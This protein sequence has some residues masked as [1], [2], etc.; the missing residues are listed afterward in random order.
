MPLVQPAAVGDFDGLDD[1]DDDGLAL[2]ES[3]GDWDGLPVGAWAAAAG[4]A[5][6]D[7]L[8]L[9]DG[10]PVGDRDGELDGLPVGL[11]LGL[12]VGASTLHVPYGPDAG[13][14]VEPALSHVRV[15]AHPSSTQ[16]SWL[17]A[18]RGHWLAGAPQSTSV[19]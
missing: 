18:H 3:V 13:V 17:V 16:Q 7:A 15:P 19:S 5:L 4:D 2:G 8:G 12:P 11:A 14:Q 10:L 1:G 9:A 6:G